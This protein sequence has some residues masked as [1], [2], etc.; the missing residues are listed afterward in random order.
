MLFGGRGGHFRSS[1][2]V[3]RR[4]GCQVV[5]GR[6]RGHFR[7]GHGLVGRGASI[8]GERGPVLSVLEGLGESVCEGGDGL[9][10][11]SDGALNGLL[12]GTRRLVPRG[13][14]FARRQAELL[15]D[16]IRL[17][18][19]R[20][21]HIKGEA[22]GLGVVTRLAEAEPEAMPVFFDADE[23]DGDDVPLFDHVLRVLDAAAGEFGDVDK[24]FDGTIKP[25]KG[26]EGH[27]LRDAADEDLAD[28]ETVDRGVPLFGLCALQREGDLLGLA[29]HFEDVGL[30][31]L[32][33]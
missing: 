20:P 30:D 33:D 1:G 10:V 4:H 19:D 3:I 2:G 15:A 7:G 27:E 6:G 16:V 13:A 21:V 31:G 8:A 32:A 25:N 26:A 22:H 24:P 14:L 17:I 5:F 23:L 29:V 28:D 18:D 9:R 11:A 12:G